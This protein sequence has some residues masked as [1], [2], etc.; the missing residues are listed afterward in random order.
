M[1]VAV[2]P[3]AM[4][5]FTAGSP[6]LRRRPSPNAPSLICSWVG[7]VLVSSPEPWRDTFVPHMDKCIAYGKYREAKNNQN[8]F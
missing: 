1:Q 6:D 5:C 3:A 2:K 8:K 4:I 7:T